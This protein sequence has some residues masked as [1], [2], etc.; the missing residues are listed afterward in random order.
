LRRRLAR[1]LAVQILYYLEMN[2]V[3]PI[4]ATDY[5]IDEV[6]ENDEGSML[7]AKDEIDSAYIM[8][9][10]AGTRK[11]AQSFDD[12]LVEYLK[13]WKLDRLSKVDTQILRLAMFEFLFADDVPRAAVINEAVDL[14]K[15]FGTADSGKFVNGV[16]GK[17]LLDID[18]IRNQIPALNS[19]D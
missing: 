4:T 19:D 5:V 14:A 2:E 9:L 15:R 11:H 10:V 6:R 16:L 13:S 7:L 8:T 12:I 17:V 18:A 1:E 3:A